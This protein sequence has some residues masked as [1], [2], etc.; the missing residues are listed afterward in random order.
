[1]LTFDEEQLLDWTEGIRKNPD[2]LN[3]FW[4]SQVKS[5]IW[6]TDWVRRY[7]P[8]AHKIVIFGAW[9]GLLADILTLRLKDTNILCND[10]D[11]E[12][13]SWCMRKYHTD[14]N[15]MEEFTYETRVDLVINTVTEHL[16]Q[17]SYD[18]WYDNIPKGTYFVIQ[19][20][21]DFKEPDHVRACSSL[22]EFN[23]INKVENTLH[24]GSMSYEGPWNEVDNRPTYYERYM[25]IGFKSEHHK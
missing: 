24:S 1:M 22:T 20:N 25:T 2:M 17:D 3:A 15:R 18:K 9:Y 19:G 13:I 21:N 23:R 7:L 4:P 5:K 8:S 10:I 11:K 14:T 12:A 16:T 6:L